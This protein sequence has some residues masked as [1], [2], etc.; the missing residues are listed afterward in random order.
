MRHIQ[1]TYFCSSKNFQICNTKNDDDVAVI[2]VKFIRFIS[3]KLVLEPAV[4]LVLEPAV[5]NLVL[6]PAVNIVLEPAVNLV[7][8]VEN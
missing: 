1:F 6:E 2:I 5:Y 4:N 3:F 7:N 8:F